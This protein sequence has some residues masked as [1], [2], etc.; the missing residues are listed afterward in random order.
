MQ[1]AAEVFSKD[2]QRPF[3]SGWKKKKKSWVFFSQTKMEALTPNLLEMEARISKGHKNWSD[4]YEKCHID[5]ERIRKCSHSKV[6]SM[7]DN[8]QFHDFPMRKLGLPNITH[9][10]PDLSP[11]RLVHDVKL[12]PHQ[13]GDSKKNPPKSFLQNACLHQKKCPKDWNQ[14]TSM[15][16]SG[17]SSWC[18]FLDL[19]GGQQSRNW[20]FKM[21]V[22]PK[23]GVGPPNHPF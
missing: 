12:N 21:W 15:R 4:S 3:G 9:C 10:L 11:K 19:K 16:R 17:S 6:P 13:F 22:F 8:Y 18:S 20:F 14:R 1:R 23:I 7:L 2:F 5:R